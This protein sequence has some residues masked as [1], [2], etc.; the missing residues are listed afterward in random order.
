MARL[1]G[2]QGL[3]MNQSNG[4]A[5]MRRYSRGKNDVG[6]QVRFS[7]SG[8]NPN[9]HVNFKVFGAFTQTNGSSDFNSAFTNYAGFFCNT[10]G[11]FASYT[12]AAWVS[13]PN[14]GMGFN[15]SNRIADF[16]LSASNN[17][18]FPGRMSIGLEIFCD[19][20]DFLSLSNL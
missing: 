10:D 16:W 2:N 14:V 5:Y 15:F 9:I 3:I 18:G 12:G 17:G 1:L 19:R 20:W 13:G 4:N 11:N 6:P 8:G 7:V